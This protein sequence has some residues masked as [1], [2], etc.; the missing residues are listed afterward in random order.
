[1]RSPNGTYSQQDSECQQLHLA[2]V[3]ETGQQPV[4]KGQ[5]QEIRRDKREMPLQGTAGKIGQCMS[6]VHEESLIHSQK[7]GPHSAK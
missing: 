2:Q 5:R 4:Y 3:G 7:V 6:S 1:M